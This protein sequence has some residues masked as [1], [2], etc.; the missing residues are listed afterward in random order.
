[1]QQEAGGDGNEG[2]RQPLLASPCLAGA[3]DP[4][5]GPEP[6]LGGE[7]K[8]AHTFR[9]DVNLL[10]PRVGHIE[11]LVFVVLALLG[12]AGRG[13]RSGLGLG[14]AVMGRA[15]DSPPRAKPGW[16]GSSSKGGRGHGQF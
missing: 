1:M 10:H 6:I 9:G 16:V 13:S 8:H 7:R 2:P 3:A 4:S 14:A 11:A 12:E 15:S 5:R